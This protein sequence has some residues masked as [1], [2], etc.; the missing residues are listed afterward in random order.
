MHR[1]IHLLNNIAVDVVT[2]LAPVMLLLL[3]F[4]CDSLLRRFLHHVA[5]AA[6]AQVRSGEGDDIRKQSIG[7]RMKTI[8]QLAEQFLRVLLGS[9]MVF[10]ILG[11]IGIDMRPVL[12]G[13]GVVGLGISLAAQNIIRAY[14]NGF[15]ILVEDQYNVGDWIQ[16]GSY[17]GT[18]EHFTLRATRIRDI[19]G[20]LI[21]MPN[22]TVQTVVNYTKGW[23]VALVKV[24]I[25]YESDYKKAR[26]IVIRLGTDMAAQK[27]G[28]ILEAPSFNG[29][30]D[31]ADN[32]VDMRILIK[33]QPG[34][35][36]SVSR[37]YRERLKEIFD[38]E[39]IEFAYPQMVVHSA[40]N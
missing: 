17:Q 8:Y 30:T 11:S 21:I 36:W 19:E 27:N 34:M 40:K 7:Y 28:I 37:E 38:E 13:I 26:E 5:N 29:I 31:F 32:S 14:I 10:W 6:I 33:T 20:S 18:V 3:W 9:A 24:A 39:G 1:Q 23:S 25:T 22:D 35:Q 12:A 16:V 15:I 2:I 4:V